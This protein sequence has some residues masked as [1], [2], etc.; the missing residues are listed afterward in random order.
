[1]GVNQGG[2][3]TTDVWTHLLDALETCPSSDPIVRLATLLHDIDK[4]ATFASNESG[5]ITFYN[6][7]VVGARTAKQIAERLRLSKRDIERIFI[8]VRYHMFYYQPEHTDAAIRR[9]MRKVGLE[10]VNDM[11]DLRE[12]DRL[13]SGA[14]KTS[15][16]LEEMKQ[17]MIE[18]LNQPF[19]VTDLAV[20]GTDLMNELHI[21]AGPVIGKVLHS[22]LEEVLENPELNTKEILI[23]KAKQIITS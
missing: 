22:L 19:D 16:R 21:P 14:K 7:E 20:D 6:H 4:P 23:Q 18:Q 13:G 3:H 15:W 11:L 17:R 1:K 9:F 5:E 2:H 12:A 10:N 8:L